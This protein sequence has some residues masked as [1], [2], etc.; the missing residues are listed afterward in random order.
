MDSSLTERA[1]TDAKNVA[2]TSEVFWVVGCFPSARSEPVSRVK[3][4]KA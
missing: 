3:T 1:A 4:I 2:D